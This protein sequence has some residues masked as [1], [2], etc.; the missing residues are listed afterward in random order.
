M[1][2]YWLPLG[3]GAHVV[4]L[5]GRVFEAILARLQHRP[6]Q[7]LFHSALEVVTPEARFIVEMTPSI[8]GSDRRPANA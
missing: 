1:Y 6:P 7:D 2:L 4:C 3:A 5:S 8:G